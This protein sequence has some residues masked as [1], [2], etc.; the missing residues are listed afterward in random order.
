MQNQSPTA[1][2]RFFPISAITTRISELLQPAITRRFWVKAEI[3]SGRERGGA[4]YCDLIETAVNGKI[5]AKISCTIWSQ[6]LTSIRSLF[7]S[8]GMDLVLTDGTVVG[9]QCSLQFSPQYGI[10]LRVI[11]ADPSFALGEMELKKRE[12]IERLQKEGLF[13]P[14]KEC[15]MPLLPQN[16][17]LISSAGSAAYNDFVQTLTMSGYGFKVYLADAMMQGDQTEKSVLRAMDALCKRGVDLIVIARGGGSKTDLY[18]LDNEAVARRIANS[19]IPVWT[20]IGHEI[21]TSVLDYVANKSFKTPTAVAEEL[22][23]RFIQMQRQLEEAAITLQTVWAY[24]FRTDRDYLDRAV[25]GIRQGPRK[26]LDVTVSN[27][28]EQAQDVRH[29][30]SERLSAE[31]IQLEGKRSQLKSLPV[32]VI[33]KQIERLAARKQNIGAQVKFALTGWTSTISRLKGRFD[34]NRYIKRLQFE[35]DSHDKSCQQLLN[36]FSAAVR[37][38]SMQQAHRKE[39]F[40]VE[41]VRQRIQIERKSLNDKMATI[42][43]LDPQNALQRGFALVYR[44]DG[45]LVRSI[46][47]IHKNDTIRTQVADGIVISEVVNKEATT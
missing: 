24:R 22:V 46:H 27:L 28:R 32:A 33:Q 13:L 29:R 40:R 35:C 3:M 43:A 9:L 38:L 31:H 2:T 20:G 16:I 17:G 34:K 5:A 21:D 45:Q 7:N 1:E 10:S 25:T 4:F 47:D 30:V 23:A 15:L 37:L 8:K 6:E 14:N 44:Q 41:K 12:I 42:R 18:F 36:R 39:R 19:I 26:L 11:D